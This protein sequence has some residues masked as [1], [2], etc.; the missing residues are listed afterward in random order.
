MYVLPKY[1]STIQVPGL[2]PSTS[3]I[4]A[5]LQIPTLFPYP[6]AYGLVTHNP[7]MCVPPPTNTPLTP[8]PP[9]AASRPV[10]CSSSLV[11]P[12]LTPRLPSSTSHLH[13][14]SPRLTTSNYRISLY[15]PSHSHSLLRPPHLQEPPTLISAAPV[16]LLQSE[17]VH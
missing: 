2:S 8:K 5:D 6:M 10:G 12:S 16:L 7:C 17:I 14:P 9:T 13:C 3:V 4:L 11:S 1:L 15:V